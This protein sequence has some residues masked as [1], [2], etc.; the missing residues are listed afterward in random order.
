MWLRWRVGPLLL[1][2]PCLHVHQALPTAP[3][4][5]QPDC[6]AIKMS[7]RTHT[8]H[9]PPHPWRSSEGRG[10]V[11]AGFAS[12]DAGS[13]LRA[14]SS[15]PFM[16]GVSFC[17]PNSSMSGLPATDHNSRLT[18]LAA[19]P[20]NCCPSGVPKGRRFRSYSSLSY[21]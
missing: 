6:L 7:L 14:P 10:R 1:S 17:V 11:D 15:Y 4:L 5:N 16:V 9:F 18:G 12:V 21:P 8:R 2:P 13:I 20:L 19:A 3:M